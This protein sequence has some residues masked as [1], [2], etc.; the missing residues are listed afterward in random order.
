MPAELANRRAGLE[1][2]PFPSMC[3]IVLHWHGDDSVRRDV[4]AE[5]HRTLRETAAPDN[6]AA[7]WFLTA[8]SLIFCVLLGAM[9]FLI[10]F[11]KLR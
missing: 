8:A 2:E 7:N 11:K 9:L 3:N 10:F 4:E 1:L 6:P 5:L